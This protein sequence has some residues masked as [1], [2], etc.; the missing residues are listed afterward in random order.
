MRP[1]S[2]LREVRPYAGVDG[3]QDAL[4][5]LKLEFGDAVV[6]QAGRT[7]VSGR[8]YLRDRVGIRVG[9]D[10]EAE[11]FVKRLTAAVE[12][13][14]LE[15]AQC[16][17][18]VV[19]STSRLKISDVV[20][21][22]KISELGDL[23]PV[24]ELTTRDARPRALQTPFGTFSVDVYVLLAEQMPP[25]PLRPW[26]KG[27]WLARAGFIV[28]T[29]LAEISFSPIP[30]DDETRA[31]LGLPQQS[32]RYVQITEPLN[33]EPP[34]DA[35]QLFVDAELLSAL[36]E[37]P[38][39]VGAR[40]FQRQLFVDAMTALIFEA[41][42]QLNTSARAADLAD[43]DG[44]LLYQVLR[45]TV[46]AFPDG[47]VT[48]DQRNA[49]EALLLTIRHE[50]AKAVTEVETSIPDLRKSLKSSITEARR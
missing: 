39:T 28:T 48:R 45:R 36:A 22:S 15:A 46:G 42:S 3:I 29:G 30:L 43:L 10:N 35:L 19:A 34:L 18:V 11:I 6:E 13:A 50:P 37:N 9:H 33:P 16:E 1:Q 41:N 40:A 2:E 38:H 26:R 47:L 7:T 8:A 24:V 20:W 14:D 49:M 4:S 31:R 27:T 12:Q 32:I 23:G 5:D 21:R 17:L 25:R 44:S